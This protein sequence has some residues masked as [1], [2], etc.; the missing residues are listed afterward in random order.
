MTQN[1]SSTKVWKQSLRKILRVKKEDS[2]FVY[3][4]LEAQEGITSYSTLDYLPQDPNRD[5]ELTYSPD[6][7]NEV[8]SLIKELGALVY[9]IAPD[10][11]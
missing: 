9:E 6:F 3:F 10:S 11:R 1:E 4:I 7:E 5:L 8:V 2:A